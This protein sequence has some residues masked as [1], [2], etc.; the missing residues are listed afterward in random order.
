MARMS[1]SSGPSGDRTS[2]TGRPKFRV[3]SYRDGDGRVAKTA[4]TAS[5]YAKLR[6]AGRLVKEHG[7]WRS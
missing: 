7:G 4:V 1:L 2:G 5:E 6:T 3:V